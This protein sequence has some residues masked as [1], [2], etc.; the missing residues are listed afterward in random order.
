[1]PPPR[2]IGRSSPLGATVVDGG[3]NFSLFSRTAAGVELLFFD[4]E[5]DATPSRVVRIDPATNRTY[6]YW[7]VF[8]P[9][10][11]PGQLYGYRVEGPSD[12]ASGLR[13]DPAKVLLDPYA[14]GV[15]VPEGYD[16]EAARR[17]GDN[18]AT[19]MKSV[20]VDP[21]A[22]DW[23]GDLPLGRP[24]RD[25]RS[26][27]A[28]RRIRGA[29]PAGRRI[30]V[31]DTARAAHTTIQRLATLP[32]RVRGQVVATVGHG[33]VIPGVLG[34]RAIQQR[35]I[36][37]RL[38]LVAGGIDPARERAGR[39]IAGV[40][41]RRVELAGGTAISARCAADRASRHPVDTTR[42]AGA[43]VVDAGEADDR[44]LLGD[45][46]RTARRRQ[47]DHLRLGGVGPRTL[48]DGRSG[49]GSS[50][51]TGAGGPG[52][53]DGRRRTDISGPGADGHPRTA[54][55]IGRSDVESQAGTAHGN[56]GF[57]GVRN[58]TSA[59]DHAGADEGDD[60]GRK[61]R[62]R[63]R[64]RPWHISSLAAGGRSRHQRGQAGCWESVR[65]PQKFERHPARF[66]APPTGKLGLDRRPNTAA[67]SVVPAA[68]KI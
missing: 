3:V 34:G 13:F 20:V 4:R 46:A 58:R 7:H 12:P 18:A 50:E 56:L 44:G 11:P 64:T 39:V 61:E 51:R 29:A 38:S 31:V 14:R 25:L 5:D 37:A 52:V 28:V 32:L 42:P 66:H 41:N 43:A 24:V 36:V 19:A 63:R 47:E 59:G 6:H 21:G 35:A 22:Y 40:S 1:M 49:V 26:R 16:R 60:E 9:R 53:R 54:L 30:S 62:F 48:V 45:R 27:R 65:F 2:T 33:N 17:E 10:V 8:V 68:A 67:C 57:R 23:E 15:V 55:W